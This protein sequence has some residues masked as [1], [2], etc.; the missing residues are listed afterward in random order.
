MVFDGF[1]GTGSFG[2][3][4]LSRGASRCV[5]IERDKRIADLLHENIDAL[6][7]GERAELVRGDALGPGALSRCPRPVT[8]AL[9]DPPYA[10]VTDEAGWNRV[11]LQLQRLVDLLTDDGFAIVRTPWPF[12]HISPHS[13]SPAT[14][15]TDELDDRPVASI[16]ADLSLEN[17]EGPETHV[18]RSTAVH[19]YMKA[20]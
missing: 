5:F 10:M 6:D 20:R 2:L 17:A 4:A 15:T 13:H 18:Y 19:L 14:G 7:V 3:E 16:E 11:K 8:I 9:L 1:A 12:R